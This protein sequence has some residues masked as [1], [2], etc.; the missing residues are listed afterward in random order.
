MPPAAAANPAM[1]INEKLFGFARRKVR[2]L[3]TTRDDRARRAARVRLDEVETRLRWLGALL[4]GAD[5]P[6]EIAVAEGAGGIGGSTLWLPASFDFGD[7]RDDNGDAFVFRVAYAVTSRALGFGLPTDL[8]ERDRDLATLLALP[9]TIEALERDCPG[10]RSLRLRLS[11]MLLLRERNRLAHAQSGGVLT[12]LHFALLGESESELTT[13]FGSDVA[14]TA[15]AL[16]AAPPAPGQLVAAVQAARTALHSGRGR[17]HI[18][19]SLSGRLMSAPATSA[20]DTAPEPPAERVAGDALPQGTE[21][22]APP[23][24]QVTRVTPKEQRDGDSPL[25]HVFEKLFTAEEYQGG[26][27]RFD[28][29]DELDEHAEAL[30]ELQLRQVVRTADPTASLYSADLPLDA[31]TPDLSSETPAAEL[32]HYDEWDQARRRYRPDWCALEVTRPEAEPPSERA[33]AYVRSV[34]QRYASEIRRLRA[35]LTRLHKRRAPR[36]RQRSGSDVDLDAVV[37]RYAATRAAASGHGTAGADRLYIARRPHRPELATL[38]LID[39]SLST[40]SWVENRRVLDVARDAVLILG[41]VLGEELSVAVGGF[42]SNSRRHCHYLRVKDFGDSW[43]A[44]QPRVLGLRPAGYTRIGPA[45]RHA[46]AVL[47]QAKAR[48]R[49]LLLISDGKPTDYDHYEGRHGIADVRQALRE[50]HRDGVATFALAIEASAKNYLPRMFGTG[51]YEILPHPGRL[52]T[53][54]VRLHERLLM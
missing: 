48:R 3:L 15:R 34:R 16:M 1:G 49:L 38:V 47:R 44:A 6:V 8:D 43:R 20:I 46:T 39:T 30:D 2:Q 22:R 42:Y 51:G 28:G 32:L 7:S 13:R 50:A 33:T 24:E 10:A 40:D 23:R 54:L 29:S 52:P 45:L 21:R 25:M 41:E 19:L 37:D 53:S 27:R 36:N 17:E 31:A 18:E 4:A 14:T 11:R 12:C 5:H 35:D 9:R 26:D